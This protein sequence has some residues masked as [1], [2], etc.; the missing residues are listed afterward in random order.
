MYLLFN[1]FYSYINR[2][3]QNTEL[4]SSLI[5]KIYNTKNKYLDSHNLTVIDNSPFQDFTFKCYGIPVNPIRSSLLEGL[6]K[7]SQGKQM[8]FKYGFL[9]LLYLLRIIP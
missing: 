1:Y 4:Y 3:K 6:G 9:C 5:C 8:K 2:D 7:K